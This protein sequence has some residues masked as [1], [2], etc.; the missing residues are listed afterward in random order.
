MAE[1]E[2][3]TTPVEGTPDQ[4]AAARQ[5]AHKRARQGRVNRHWLLYAMVLIWAVGYAIYLWRW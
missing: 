3:R 4:R 5:E 2:K 1:S